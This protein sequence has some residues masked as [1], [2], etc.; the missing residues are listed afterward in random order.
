METLEKQII[1]KTKELMN[2]IST[3]NL[4]MGGNHRYSLN[5]KSH[6]L[7]TELNALLYEEYRREYENN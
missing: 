3:V 2:T 4:D 1:E 5:H 7:I 6:K